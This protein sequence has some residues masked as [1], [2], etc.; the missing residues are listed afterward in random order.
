MSY[1][2]G[3]FKRTSLSITSYQNKELENFKGLEDQ[4]NIIKYDFKSNTIYRCQR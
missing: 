3:Q 4:K 2:V 1:K